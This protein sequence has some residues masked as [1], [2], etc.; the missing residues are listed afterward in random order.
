MDAEGLADR[1]VGAVLDEMEE[2]FGLAGGETDR[3]EGC[4]GQVNRAWEYEVAADLLK[5]G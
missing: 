2:D 5:L 1:F 4:L 3:D